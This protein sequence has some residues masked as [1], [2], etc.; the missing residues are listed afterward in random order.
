MVRYPQTINTLIS[1][2]KKL[3]GVGTK[4]AERYAFQALNWHQQSLSS[5]G[6]LLI[7]LKEKVASCKECGC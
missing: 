4:T 3:P 7:T 6:E 2:F 1:F 5:L